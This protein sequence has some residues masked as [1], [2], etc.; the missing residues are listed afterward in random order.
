MLC[1]MTATPSRCFVY[2]LLRVEGGGAESGVKGTIERIGTAQRQDF[3][4]LP[5][6]MGLLKQWRDELNIEPHIMSGNE[7]PAES[8]RR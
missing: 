1:E 5:E 6:L 4:D 2:L 8:T 7:T 3:S